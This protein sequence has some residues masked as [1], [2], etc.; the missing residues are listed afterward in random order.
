LRLHRSRHITAADRSERFGIPVTSP[1]R[2]LI[3][4]AG[5]V[6]G[7]TLE[8]ALES[9]LRRRLTSPSQLFGRL[10]EIGGPGRRGTATL[11]HLLAQRQDVPLESRFEVLFERLLRRHGLPVPVR[12]REVVDESGRKRIDFAY[13][14]E[15]IAIECVSW[16]HHSGRKAW[17]ADMRRRNALTAKGWRVLEFTWED[18]L[19]RGNETASRIREA[20]GYSSSAS[21]NSA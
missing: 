8:T 21:S 16:R 19:R 1:T 4:L 17:Q 7:E 11:R 13:E 12:Q 10:T 9:A 15:R 2:T 3:D 14:R 6:D 18:V 20:L 5:V